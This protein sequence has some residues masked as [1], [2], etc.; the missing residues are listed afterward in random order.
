MI[1][2]R[3]HQHTLTNTNPVAVNMAVHYDPSH[4]KAIGTQCKNK[5][6]PASAVQ[7]MYLYELQRES[8]VEALFH[9]QIFRLAKAEE[10]T[11]TH[12]SR[13]H[14][15]EAQTKALHKKLTT[16]D[17]SARLSTSAVRTE[18]LQ[19]KLSEHTLRL[20][21]QATRLATLETPA[22]AANPPSF[23]LSEDIHTLKTSLGK[24]DAEIQTLFDE[25][26]ALIT[27]LNQ[28]NS[29]I[30]KLED[31]V[32]AL[33]LQK[34]APP[35]AAESVQLLP[36]K[37]KNGETV[38]LA[39]PKGQGFRTFVP[40]KKSSNGN[41]AGEPRV[42]PLPLREKNGENG[43]NV[44]PAMATKG[45]GKGAVSLSRD[46]IRAFVPGEPWVSSES[47]SAVGAVRAVG[48]LGGREVV[49]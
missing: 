25:R 5:L 17:L 45:K 28:S 30:D 41:P 21:E 40:G 44:D 10:E 2:I 36:L 11:Q 26:D 38:D 19:A 42:Q 31:L 39:V 4:L 3:F 32:R 29:R 33:T 7:A 14:H 37:A 13:I 27:L 46:E 1:P 43:E 48:K 22:A 12:S 49:W 47:N 18:A 24:V 16:N 34:T 35:S 20:D 8:E 9:G 6:P 23:L 15:L